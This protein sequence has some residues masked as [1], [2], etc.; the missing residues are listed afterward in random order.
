LGAIPDVLRDARKLY[1][2]HPPEVPPGLPSSLLERRPDIRET[3]QVLRARNAQVGVAVADFFPRLSLTALLGQV[4]PELSMLTSGGAA[5][6]SVAGGLAGPLFQGGRLRGAYQQTLALHEEARLRYQQ[7]VLT[8]FQ[9]VSD[10][11]VSRT[12]FADGRVQQARAVKA[13]ETAVEVSRERY[14][15]GKAGY[16]ELLQQQQLLFPAENI[17]VRTQLNEVLALIQL[18]R[19]L[20]GGWQVR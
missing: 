8:A 14:I 17:L 4:S 19:A 10:A 18:Y 9:E 6:W 5:A 1:D 15:A 11:L 20:G 12:A 16:Y 2:F 13:Y 7:V 3:E